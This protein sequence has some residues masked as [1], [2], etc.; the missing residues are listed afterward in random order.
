MRPLKMLLLFVAMS[1]TAYASVAT[2]DFEST[3]AGYYQGSLIQTNGGL[4]LTVTPEGDPSGFLNVGGPTGVALLGNQSLVGS[5]TNPLQSDRFDPVRFAF[6]SP[7]TSITFAFG[8]SGGDDDSPVVITGFDA[9]G[10]PLGTLTTSYP[11]GYAAGKT[12]SGNFANAA[13]FILTSGPHTSGSNS[14][15][16]Y[17]EVPTVQ[18]GATPEPGTLIMFGSG[19]VGLAGL[20]RRKVNL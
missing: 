7:V 12:L 19:V 10:N 8:D 17:W 15:S 6:S 2:F 18:F 3:P 13:Y 1:S 14:D 5:Q 9:G 11:A 4:T 20:L 16:I